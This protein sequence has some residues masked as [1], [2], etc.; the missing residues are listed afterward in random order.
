MAVKTIEMNEDFF[1]GL[2]SH[3][4]E[5]HGVDYDPEDLDLLEMVVKGHHQYK[6]EVLGANKN[7]EEPVALELPGVVTYTA[8]YRA[9]A[10][11]SGGNFGIGIVAGEELKETANDAA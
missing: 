2:A 5:N 9:G 11:E 6:G 3:L 4:V 7:E 10:D 8:S 1:K